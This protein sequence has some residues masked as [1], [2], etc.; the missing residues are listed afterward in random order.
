[1]DRHYLITESLKDHIRFINAESNFNFH[2][3]LSDLERRL[4]GIPALDF[5][6]HRRTRKGD[7]FADRFSCE[8]K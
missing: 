3:L 2:Q 1:M 4:S 8:E 5:G 6:G 7:A